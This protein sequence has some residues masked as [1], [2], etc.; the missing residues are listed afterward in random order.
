MK[1]VISKIAFIVLA[2]LGSACIYS[3]AND[4]K[5]VAESD[6]S[7]EESTK[8]KSKTITWEGFGTGLSW[9]ANN[10]GNDV[11]GTDLFTNLLFST[12]TKQP[13]KVGETEYKMPGLGLN[14]ARMD[15]GSTGDLIKLRDEYKRLQEGKELGLER[16]DKCGNKTEVYPYDDP[17]DEDEDENDDNHDIARPR[18]RYWGSGATTARADDGG[19]GNDDTMEVYGDD[20]TVENRD[21]DEDNEDLDE[22]E[23]PTKTRRR[24]EDD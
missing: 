1:L 2:L 24:H 20:D 8:Y 22:G 4:L 17:K 5:N 3:E 18:P 16:R 12:N 7:L 23:D 21:E 9:W 10:L 19:G 6:S 15:L 11:D 14:L 13:V